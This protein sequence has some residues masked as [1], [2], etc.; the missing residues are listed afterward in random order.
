MVIDSGC[1]IEKERVKSIFNLFEH[2][3]NIPLK[4]SF[5]N[6]A[7]KFNC[8]MIVTVIIAAGL[9]LTIA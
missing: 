4:D 6:K 8:F 7:C 9:G 2:N 5:K 1:G 3:E